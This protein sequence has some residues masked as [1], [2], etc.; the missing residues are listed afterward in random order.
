MPVLE[1]RTTGCST[2]RPRS[3]LLTFVE[4]PKGPAVIGTNA[5]LDVD[6]AWVKNLAANPTAEIRLQGK[7]QAVSARRVDGTRYDLIW[8]TAVNANPQYADYRATLSR[9]VP[10]IVLERVSA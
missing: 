4:Q 3:V 6:P 5:G 8:Q 10:I 2:G 7:W 9:P 1:L